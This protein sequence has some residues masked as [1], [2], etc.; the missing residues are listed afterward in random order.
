LGQNAELS[1]DA[2]HTVDCATGFIL[3]ERKAAFAEDGG[4]ASRSIRTHSS[5]DYTEGAVLKDLRDGVHKK[6]NRP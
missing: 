1:A 4:H 3:P 6:V 5:H 2:G